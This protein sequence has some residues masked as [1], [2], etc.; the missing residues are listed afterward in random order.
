MDQPSNHSH[1]FTD[2]QA[3]LFQQLYSQSSMG[4]APR[5]WEKAGLWKRGC[6]FFC[7]SDSDRNWW[8]FILMMLLWDFFKKRFCCFTLCV[9]LIERARRLKSFCLLCVV[10]GTKLCM[11]P[12]MGVEKTICVSHANTERVWITWI[13]NP[14]DFIIFFSNVFL[15]LP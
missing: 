10:L 15:M 9:F 4:I 14:V 6:P 12:I 7:F 13:S 11:R 3:T 1:P 8:K 2:R 5:W